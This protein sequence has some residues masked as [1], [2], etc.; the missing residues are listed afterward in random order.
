MNLI[1]NKNYILLILQK[2]LGIL[3][4]YVHFGLIIICVV[5]YQH[6][7][8]SVHSNFVGIYSINNFNVLNYFCSFH[9]VLSYVLETI[10]FII[11]K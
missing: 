11:E 9:I 5:K 10:A 1:T 3:R 7:Q 8:T 4:L 6:V 2:R